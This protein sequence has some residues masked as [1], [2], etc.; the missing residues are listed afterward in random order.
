MV[1]AALA[2][3]SAAQVGLAL[4]VHEQLLADQVRVSTAHAQAMQ[5]A[6]DRQEDTYQLLKRALARQSGEA[7]VADLE[8]EW[9]E[10]RSDVLTRERDLVLAEGGGT[11]ITPEK[12]QAL[13]ALAENIERVWHDPATGVADRKRLLRCLIA[14]VVIRREAQQL[15]TVIHWHSASTT[16]FT[17]NVKRARPPQGDATSAR[18]GT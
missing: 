3:L 2:A 1:A 18:Q 12:E 17:V 6:R 10:A 14:S 4:K 11:M 9:Q 16:A 5:Q 13:Y 15:Y 8:R 7:L